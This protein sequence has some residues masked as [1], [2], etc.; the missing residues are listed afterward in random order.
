LTPATQVHAYLL[1]RTGAQALLN[2]LFPLQHAL[3]HHLAQ[4]AA[5]GLRVWQ[6]RRS[7]VP[8]A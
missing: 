4:R 7:V 3:P 1:T 8:P 6:T 5:Q 2:E